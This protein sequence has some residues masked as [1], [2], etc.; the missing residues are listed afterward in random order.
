MGL[1]KKRLTGFRTVESLGTPKSQWLSPV[2]QIVGPA[3]LLATSETELQ[4]L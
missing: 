3:D 2:G 4:R 1:Q